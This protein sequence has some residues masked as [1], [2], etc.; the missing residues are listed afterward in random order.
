MYILHTRGRR[1]EKRA[2]GADFVEGHR[3]NFNYVK[4]HTLEY[5]YL[6]INPYLAFFLRQIL[7]DHIL[8]ISSAITLD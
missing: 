1:N 3:Q 7:T 4:I 6:A 2:R 8:S 5:A